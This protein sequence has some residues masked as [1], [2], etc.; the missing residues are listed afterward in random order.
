MSHGAHSDFSLASDAP[1]PLAPSHGSAAVCPFCNSPS[2]WVALLEQGGELGKHIKQTITKTIN[3]MIAR[4]LALS[5]GCS[6]WEP[7]TKLRL[8]SA[9]RRFISQSDRNRAYRNASKSLGLCPECRRTKAPA[10][11]VLCAN[12]RDERARRKRMARR[13]GKKPCACGQ[14]AVNILHGEYICA[15]CWR[16]E[17]GGRKPQNI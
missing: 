3:N 13:I 7:E 8:R 4:G 1:A 11:Y 16:I 5:D 2:R 10:G 17:R 6:S 14:P 15:E 9:T 12:C